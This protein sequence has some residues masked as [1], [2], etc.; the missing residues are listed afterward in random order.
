MTLTPDHPIFKL[1]ISLHHEFDLW[2]VPEWFPERLQNDFPQV[3]VVNLTAYDVAEEQIRDAEVVVSWLLSAEAAKAAR[4]LRWLHSTSAAVH[5]LLYPEILNSDII[6]TNG[7]EVHAAVVAEHIIALVLALARKLP[8]A[9]RFQHRRIW[10]QQDIWRIQPCPREVAGA[11]LGLIGLGNIGREAARRA[12]A[13]GMRVIAVREHPEKG[14]PD[15]VNKVLG[16]EQLDELL[17][18]SDY[19]V[20]AVPV[21]RA[22]QNLINAQRFAQM[23]PDARLIN[24]GR[25]PLVDEGALIQALREGRIAGAALDVFVEE[26]LPSDSL[27]WDME[28]VLITPHTASNSDKQWER[29]YS[30]V[31]ENLRRYLNHEPL[32]SVVDKQRGY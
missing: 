29:Q 17:K 28:H 23:K 30:L 20:L 10:G 15:G 32:L 6:L 4:K 5:Q 27:L 3:E 16:P 1:L 18:E 13:L 8:E 24:V 19:V 9:A 14:G 12:A 22:T 26:P 7:S 31:A 21:T 2:R 11:T 25:G